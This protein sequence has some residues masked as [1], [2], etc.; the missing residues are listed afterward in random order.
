M[1]TTNIS[2]NTFRHKKT[3]SIFAVENPSIFHSLALLIILC[4]LLLLPHLP[5]G[6]DV[7]LLFVGCGSPP[8]F[9]SFCCVLCDGLRWCCCSP[10]QNGDLPVTTCVPCFWSLTFCSKSETGSI[11]KVS[12]THIFSPSWLWG[13]LLG[14]IFGIA[15]GGNLACCLS[16]K[17]TTPEAT[18]NDKKGSVNMLSPKKNTVAPPVISDHSKC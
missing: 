12:S 10:L 5:L 8:C 13:G 11:F 7:S 15:P 3:K 17:P 6:A 16:L 18:R 14:R 2:G 4:T 1:N 9:S